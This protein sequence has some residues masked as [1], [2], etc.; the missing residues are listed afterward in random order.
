ME[1]SGVNPNVQMNR[2]FSAEE[3]NVL[4]A[5]VAEFNSDW[6]AKNKRV[7]KTELDKDD[8]LLILVKQLSNQDPT[9]PVED[10]QF[11]AQMAQFS[12]LEQMTNMANGFSRLSE[13]I[14]ASQS[15]ALVGREVTVVDGETTVSG[16]VEEVRGREFPQVKI[17]GYY[18]SFEKVESVRS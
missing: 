17:N 6:T 5:S 2:Y 14:A 15:A 11:I 8:F 7:A 3:K 13:T 9:A 1:L 4:D 16:V 10:K 12:S 18:Y